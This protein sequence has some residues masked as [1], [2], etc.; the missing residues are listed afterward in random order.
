MSI[1]SVVKGVAA[2]LHTFSIARTRPQ[3]QLGI[4]VAKSV[5]PRVIAWGFTAGNW[6]Y[7]T[8]LSLMYL[9]LAGH[10]KLSACMCNTDRICFYQ[11][12]KKSVDRANS[13][14][15][16]W[17]RDNERPMFW[18]LLWRTLNEVKL[19]L[20]KLIHQMCWLWNFQFEI[21]CYA[22]QQT[23]NDARIWIVRSD[24]LPDARIHIHRG[25]RR[26][27]SQQGN[28]RS[29]LIICFLIK[30]KHDGRAQK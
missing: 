23:Q 19:Y 9:S 24:A 11:L 12:E 20:Y 5:C 30:I 26:D 17:R 4:I 3:N 28:V 2:P 15:S 22:F 13:D 21:Q 1:E 27:F 14:W 29:L 25:Q 16:R 6:F 7:S 10:K 18:F 8:F